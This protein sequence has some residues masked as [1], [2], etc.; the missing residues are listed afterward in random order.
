MN[1]LL[2]STV[3]FGFFLMG[4]SPAPAQEVLPK[5]KI[6]FQLDPGASPPGQ[7]KIDAQFIQK[8]FDVMNGNGTLDPAAMSKFIERLSNGHV[9]VDPVIF[10]RLQARIIQK[11][12]EKLGK[13][14]ADMLFKK[15]DTNNDN[16]LTKTE[17]LKIADEFREVIGENRME[18]ARLMLGQRYDVL[19]PGGIG[20]TRDQFRQE[21]ERF[22]KEKAGK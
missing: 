19:D 6:K 17:F 5:L 9:L 3:V 1:K 22:L 14:D 20:L 21:V 16:K 10:Q 15:L 18:F 11:R 2:T 13:I 4:A 7:D 8:L 12:L